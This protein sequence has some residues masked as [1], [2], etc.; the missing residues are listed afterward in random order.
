M[1]KNKPVI[2]I[3]IPVYNVAQFLPRC[4]D[5]LIKQTFTD[6]QAICVNDG[7]TD[8]SAAILAEYA[9]RDVRFTII[10][11]KNGGI[12]DARNVGMQHVN[13]DYVMFVDSDDFI[14]PQTLE[15]M[16]YIAGHE[17]AEM[18]LFRFDEAFHKFA[19]KMMRAGHDITKLLP[20]KRNIVYDKT[21]VRF[22]ETG[23]ILMHCTERNRGFGVRRPVR[24]H[25]FPVL[26]LYRRELVENTPFI[27][28]II[29]EDFPWWSTILLHRPRTVITKLPLYFYMPNAA[30]VLN[31]SKVLRM[32]ESLAVGLK[33]V[34]D[35]YSEK[36]SAIEFEY[37][38]REFLWPFII[39]IMR[40]VREL[41][42][43][44]DIIAA[45]KIIRKLYGH[46][47]MDNPPSTRAR[48]YWRRIQN[49]I[50]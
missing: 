47:I 11:K 44:K 7:S 39:I 30:S 8:S 45:K 20:P 50:A 15:I 3:I 31:S 22:W 48:R 10:N 33:Y 43:S 1:Q 13:G 35:L 34:Y 46:G 21:R 37:Y 36:A 19:R 42:N 12:S 29:M 18:A 40:K 14:H 49:F 24:R 17:S 27:N 16:H 4:L 23:N 26:G 9:A 41:D 25:C 32:I 6:W 5:S 28:G 2:S 38:K